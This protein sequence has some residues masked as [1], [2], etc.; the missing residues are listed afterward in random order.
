MQVAAGVV[1]APY[2]NQYGTATSQTG[3][4]EFHVGS[5]STT[6]GLLGIADA[7]AD[8]A[9]LYNIAGQNGNINNPVANSTAN[10]FTVP[11]AEIDT[12]GNVLAACVDSG[13]NY[14]VAGAAPAQVRRAA[15]VCNHGPQR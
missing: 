3:M 12:L 10:T 2:T 8:A 13:N 14:Y 9:N 5:T 4:D 15:A 6:Q 11:Q 1:L 7:A